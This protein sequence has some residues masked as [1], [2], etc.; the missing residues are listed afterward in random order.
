MGYLDETIGYHFNL[1]CSDLKKLSWYIDK[2]YASHSDM[3]GQSGAVLM[4]GDCAVLFKSNK[5]KVNTRGSTETELIAV[6][7]ALPTV[8]WT[9]SFMME[10]GYNL[11]MEIK[12]DN[13]STLLLMRNGRLSSG[14]R[15][16]HLELDTFM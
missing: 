14:K 1:I 6:D 15:A 16:K 2:S 4:T 13:R 8:Q 12:E 10:Q 5:Q 3:K 9:K 7:D 11:D